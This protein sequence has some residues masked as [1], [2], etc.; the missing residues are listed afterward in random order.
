MMPTE[1]RIAA[2]WRELLARDGA[3]PGAD[4]GPDDDFFALGGTSMQAMALV[5]R[6]REEFGVQVGLGAVLQDPTLRA[7]GAAVTAAGGAPEAAA[8]AGTRAAAEG[9][10]GTGRP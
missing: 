4:I 8:P 7:V 6:L 9:D 2:I 1:E 3:G 10:G 5:Q